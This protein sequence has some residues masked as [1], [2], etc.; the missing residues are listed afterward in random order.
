MTA[1]ILITAAT[2]S[3][4]HAITIYTENMTSST[5]GRRELLSGVLY[6]QQVSLLI[7]GPGLGNTVQAITAAIEAARPAMII[8]TGCA[9]VF[10]ETGLK[11]GDIAVA[12]QEIDIQMGIEPVHGSAPTQPLPFPILIKNGVEIKRRYLLNEEL[13]DNTFAILTQAFA[14]TDVNIAKG[15]FITVSTITA[16]DRRAADIF[17]HYRPCMEAMEGAGAAHLAC[18]Y[19]IPLIEI[20]AASNFVGKRDKHQWNLPLAFQRSTAAVKE[21]IRC[22]KEISSYRL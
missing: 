7:T 20:R 19:D 1:S 17:S 4:M 21:C 8:N 11:I 3:E 10:K 5:V 22:V 6:G 14:N 13:T 2:S 9:G 18:F 15:P 12:T 16:T